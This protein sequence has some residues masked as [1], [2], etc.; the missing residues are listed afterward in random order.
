MA[1]NLPVFLAIAGSAFP[2]EPSIALSLV[3]ETLLVAY[4]YFGAGLIW[5]DP[6]PY[7]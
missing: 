7:V 2:S 5:H 4:V 3:V 1:K 6:N